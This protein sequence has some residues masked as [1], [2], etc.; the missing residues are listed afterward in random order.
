[1][2]H[3]FH[4]DLSRATIKDAVAYIRD[5]LPSFDDD[6]QLTIRLLLTGFPEFSVRTLVSVW[7]DQLDK[8]G[9]GIAAG[10][11]SAEFFTARQAM[12][13]IK[14]R[15]PIALLQNATVDGLGNVSCT[16]GMHF[17]DVCLEGLPPLRGEL[18]PAEWRALEYCIALHE[19]KAGVAE[20]VQ[21]YPELAERLAGFSPP[22]LK[23][24]MGYIGD[25]Q[26]LGGDEPTISIE[27][28]RSA[29]RIMALRR[30]KHGQYADGFLRNEANGSEIARS[31]LGA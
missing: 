23:V 22:P 9:N 31:A 8:N 6:G 30:P 20:R 27:T 26:P 2:T 18:R 12:D 24:I 14:R 29:L 4:P 21:F 3:I 7:S 28:L 16:N 19:G 1:M 10:M 5:K 15:Y 13:G 17:Y 11:A 25:N